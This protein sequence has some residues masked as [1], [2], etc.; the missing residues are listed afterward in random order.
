M[1]GDFRAER[2]EGIAEG[3][4]C[5]AVTMSVG[6]RRAL[7]PVGFVDDGDMLRLD[8]NLRGART[9]IDARRD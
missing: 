9:H 4:P 2:I 3:E 6:A 7:L 8:F 1:R 5:V